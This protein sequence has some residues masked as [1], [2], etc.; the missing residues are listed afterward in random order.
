MQVEAILNSRPL[1]PLSN[2]PNDLEPLTPGH[3]LIGEA[4]T[5]IPQVDVTS[6]KI[7][8]L[9]HYHRLQKLVQHFW[10]RWQS[11]VLA[12]LQPRTKWKAGDPP[13]KVG[14]LVLLREENLPPMCWQLGRIIALF[15]GEDK[16]SRVAEVKTR[17]G[18]VRMAIRK[19]AK[20]PC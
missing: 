6:D 13:V 10:R 9:S 14:D 11:E 18:S 2:D 12:N 4:L 16:V 1:V 20:L 5:T 3:F 19:L 8:R 15:P 17:H 7:N